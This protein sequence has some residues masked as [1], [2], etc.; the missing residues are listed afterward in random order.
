MRT[1]WIGV[2]LLISTF[3]AAAPWTATASAQDDASARDASAQ[4]DASPRDAGAQD[5][6]EALARCRAEILRW[7]ERL[8]LSG[9]IHLTLPE[10]TVSV[11]D[12]TRQL[13][14]RTGAELVVVHTAER[15]HVVAPFLGYRE[16]RALSQEAGAMAHG[17][18]LCRIAEILGAHA[19]RRLALRRNLLLTGLGAL[20]LAALWLWRPPFRRRTEDRRPRPRAG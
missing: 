17:P 16:S 7:G 3:L 9:E 11:V 4:D 8:N 6:A 5:D 1:A 12:Y 10:G 19:S 20:L 14:R 2:I 13:R 15:T 18:G